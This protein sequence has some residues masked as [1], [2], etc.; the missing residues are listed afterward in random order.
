MCACA[1]ILGMYSNP[2]VHSTFFSAAFSLVTA[3]IGR[4]PSMIRLDFDQN[5]YNLWLRSRSRSQSRSSRITDKIQ[6]KFGCQWRDTTMI[7]RH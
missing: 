7:K 3:M 1:E 5:Q 6:P 4:I 2:S